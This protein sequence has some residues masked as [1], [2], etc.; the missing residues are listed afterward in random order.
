MHPFLKYLKKAILLVS[1]ALAGVAMAAGGP[2]V[3]TW[4]PANTTPALSVVGSSITADTIEVK[5]YLTST[6]QANGTAPFHQILQITGFDLNGLPVSAPGFNSTYGLYFDING[7]TKFGPGPPS[8]SVLNI[9]LMADPGN[10]NGA[11]S[12]TTVAGLQF[13]NGTGGDILLGSGS[14]VSASLQLDATGTRHAQY[15]DTFAAAGGEAAFFSAVFPYLDITLTTP[16]ANFAAIAQPDGTTIDL[17]NGGS[18]LVTAA[19]PEPGSMALLGSGLVA[20]FLAS[21]RKSLRNETRYV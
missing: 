11:L 21:R 15:V 17:V 16:A 10:N 6:I 18:G 1:A 14:L 5:T 13:A 2:V 20:V 7:I 3:F 9:A 8:Y 19:A 4:S 12:A